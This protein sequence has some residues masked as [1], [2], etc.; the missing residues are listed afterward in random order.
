MDTLTFEQSVIICD[1]ISKSKYLNHLDITDC[2]FQ[3]EG[4]KILMQSLPKCNTL[5]ALNVGNNGFG[6]LKS[7]F[8]G[9]CFF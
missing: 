1:G 3:S 9:I 8:S 5:K 4:M 6:S 7:F 2:Q